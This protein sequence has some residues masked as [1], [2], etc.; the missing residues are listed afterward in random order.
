MLSEVQGQDNAVR[1][2]R[3]FVE[4][5]TRTPLL[6]V[7]EEGVGR[8][9]SAMAAIREVVARQRGPNSPEYAQVVK[10]IHPDVTFVT[11]PAD[12]EIGVDVSRSIVTLSSA[13]PTLAPFRFFLIDGAD[14][15][16]QAAANAILKVLEEPP[17]LST[18]FLLAESYDRVLFTIRSRCGRVDFRK[19]PESFILSKLSK[20][21]PDHD[22]ALV[23]ARMGEGSVGRAARYWG[24]NRITLRDRVLQLLRYWVEIDLPSA[25]SAIDDLGQDLSLALRFFGFLVHDLLVLRDDNS[26]VINLDVREELTAMQDRVRETMLAR[27]WNGLKLVLQRHEST[28]VNLPLQVKGML[29]DTFVGG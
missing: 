7:G 19:L 25:F 4:K 15:M 26:R 6:L 14:R 22:K 29:A 10:G 9:F 1:I 12:K 17:A 18:F 11:A 5:G 23:Y 3:G 16:T 27:L 24:A 20:F 2:L 8:R 13:N 21:E 28:Y